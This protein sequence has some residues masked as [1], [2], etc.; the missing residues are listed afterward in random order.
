M[1]EKDINT[2]IQTVGW[3]TGLGVFAAAFIF[4]N[5]M[6]NQAQV[7]FDQNIAGLFTAPLQLFQ[8]GAFILGWGKT[9]LLR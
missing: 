1:T 8:I 5:H 2:E 3:P 7:V 9:W 4:S 6:R